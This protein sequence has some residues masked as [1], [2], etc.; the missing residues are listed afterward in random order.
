MR[1][2]A[3]QYRARCVIDEEVCSIAQQR[4]PHH[5]IHPNR[6]PILF[7]ARAKSEQG[8]ARPQH[9]LAKRPSAYPAGHNL[10]EHCIPKG[11]GGRTSSEGG[12]A[13]CGASVHPYHRS[14]LYSPPAEG[15][16]ALSQVV[17]GDLTGDVVTHE[18]L[19]VVLADLARYVGKDDLLGLVQLYAKVGVWQ[20]LEHNT[21]KLQHILVGLHRDSCD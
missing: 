18:D 17:G 3:A 2:Q 12:S 5:L 1:A 15:D 21:L 11:F 19:N 8:S 14:P 16:A 10:L 7:A 6:S 9:D 4:S 20:R 13:H